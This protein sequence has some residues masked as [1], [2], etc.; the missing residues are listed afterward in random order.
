MY[1]TL[2][3]MMGM[4]YVGNESQLGPFFIK[5]YVTTPPIN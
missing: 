4:P 2:I 3:N 5:I 1:F